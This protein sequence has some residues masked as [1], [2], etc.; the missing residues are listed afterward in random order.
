MYQHIERKNKMALI[1]CSEC[2]KEF[3]DKASTCPNC[4][5]PT[6]EVLKEISKEQTE[7]NSQGLNLLANQNDFPNEN[8]S[9]LL[10]Q[11]ELDFI[12]ENLSINEIQDMLSK[13]NKSSIEQLNTDE[14]YKVIFEVKNSKKYRRK[15][16]K[17][18]V[19][20]VKH[21]RI[22]GIV[23]DPEILIVIMAASMV[24]VL[25]ALYLQYEGYE[26]WSWTLIII[27]GIPAVV[28]S[29]LMFA[30]LIYI[31]L[32]TKDLARYKEDVMSL[33]K[34]K[35]NSTFIDK[36]MNYSNQKV[37]DNVARCPKCG[38]ISLSGHKKGFGIGKGL[39]GTLIT[40]SPFGLIGGNFRAKK[41]RVTCL[42]CGKQFWPRKR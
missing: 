29:I 28:S 17:N 27:G 40:A 37:E 3:S 24:L 32:I 41:V 12:K 13:F 4:G 26:I 14:V 35:S 1:T 23:I 11:S 38:S 25:F 39:L 15:F 42:S 30:A 36:K 19:H 5:C 18:G 8:Y 6:M 20:K 31:V 21:L 2:N 7:R 9:T 22:K 33:N 10:A 34:S 16:D